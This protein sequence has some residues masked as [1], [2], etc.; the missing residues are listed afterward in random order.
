MY[1]TISS[2]ALCSNAVL[3][4]FAAA[5]LKAHGFK[6]FDP[7]T[8]DTPVGGSRY[9]GTGLHDVKFVRRGKRLFLRAAYDA[10]GEGDEFEVC[11][12]RYPDDMTSSFV[13]VDKKP[14]RMM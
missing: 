13:F 5:C 12:V 10:K 6:W 11:R 14:E 2:A 9:T 4:D 3:R 7:P 1:K 8:R